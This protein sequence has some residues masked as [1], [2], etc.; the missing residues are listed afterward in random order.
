M[1]KNTHIS[2][3]Q[4]TNPSNLTTAEIVLTSV[5]TGDVNFTDYIR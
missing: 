1:I 3:V 2:D 5:V 4:C